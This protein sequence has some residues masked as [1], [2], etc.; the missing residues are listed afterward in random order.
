MKQ[1]AASQGV[2]IGAV[3]P[4]VFQDEQYKLGSI[5]NPNPSV[6]EE[7]I[8]HMVECC[9]IMEKTGSTILSLWFADGTN[10]SGQDRHPRAQAPHGIRAC[11]NLQASARRMGAC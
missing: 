5:T 7:A 11:R 9:E 2:S 8:A 3:N 4:N 10:Y 1:Y 6:R